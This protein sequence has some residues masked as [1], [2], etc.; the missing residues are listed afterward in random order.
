MSRTIRGRAKFMWLC[1][2]VLNGCYIQT[3]KFTS[4]REALVK[5]TPDKLVLHMKS[6]REPSMYDVQIVGDSII[7]FDRRATLRN[8]KRVAVAADD[9]DRVITR[10]SNVAATTV[11]VTMSIVLLIGLWMSILPR[12]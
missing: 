6:G 12:T 1:V 4:S 10:K 2:V 11:A 9:V 8:R 7:G 5:P 3:G